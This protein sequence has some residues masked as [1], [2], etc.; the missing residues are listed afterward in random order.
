MFKGYHHK[1]LKRSNLAANRED[2]DF[3]ISAVSVHPAT[4]FGERDPV[5]TGDTGNPLRPHRDMRADR[6]C[7]NVA[8][9]E[10]AEF[11]G[12]QRTVAA[13]VGIPIS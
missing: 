1:S 8:D 13:A 12:F 3:S 10:P 4:A 6:Q 5:T 2:G 7:S 11:W 9:D